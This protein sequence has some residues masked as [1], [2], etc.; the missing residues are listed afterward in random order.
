V[1]ESIPSKL[2]RK[3]KYE[4]DD[5]PINYHLPK[6][7]IPDFVLPNGIHVECKGYFKSADRSKMLRIRKENSHLDI[8]FLFQR[9]NNRLT[10]SPNSMMYWEW[11]EK[12]GFIWAEGEKIPDEWYE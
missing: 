10:K 7:Y 3:V 2:R 1:W 8:R 4:P 11:A 12:H 6:R 5:P 9:A